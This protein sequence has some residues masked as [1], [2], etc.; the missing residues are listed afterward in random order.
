MDL[1]NHLPPPLSLITQVIDFFLQRFHNISRPVNGRAIFARFSL[2]PK[3]SV[4][5]SRAASLFCVDF[6]ADLALLGDRDS[7]HNEFHAACFA[8]PVFSVAMLSKVAPF[9]IAAL[10][11]LLVEEA[12]AVDLLHMLDPYLGY[13]STE[14]YLTVLNAFLLASSFLFLSVERLV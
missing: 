3:D 8:R 5:F 6:F 13:V 2:P 4:N 11:T 12:H 9:P 1:S 14:A 7:L 10:E